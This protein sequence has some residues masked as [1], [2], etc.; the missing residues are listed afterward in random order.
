MT[1]NAGSVRWEKPDAEMVDADPSPL[2]VVPH[3][4][5]Q[6]RRTR[7]RRRH[8]HPATVDSEE[9]QISQRERSRSAVDGEQHE[10]LD[11]PTDLTGDEGSTGNTPANDDDHSDSTNNQHDD[12]PDSG[13]KILAPDTPPPAGVVSPSQR[14]DQFTASSP[15]AAPMTRRQTRSRQATNKSTEVEYDDVEF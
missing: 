9:D 15:P 1:G 12:R 10:Q 8:E 7:E 3:S 4:N 6:I 13:D 14:R 11:S 2:E 5:V